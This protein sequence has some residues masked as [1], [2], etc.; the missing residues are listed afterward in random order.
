[1]DA[2]EQY[3]NGEYEKAMKLAA[4][5]KTPISDLPEEMI[6]NLKVIIDN[7]EKNKAV[8]TVVITSAVYKHFHPEQDI[9]NHQSSI[10]CGYSG[11]TFD[12]KYITPFLKEHRFPAMAE[13]GWLTRSLEQ[14]VPYNFNYH[15]AITPQSLKDAFLK[16]INYIEESGLEDSIISFLLQG[17]II[18]RDSNL[19]S[20]ATPQ[21]L[22]IS[23]IIYLLEKHFKH[24]YHS[25]GASRLPVLALYA[26][27]MCISKE[28][29]R[30]E[31]KNLLPIESH[32][33][34]DSRSGR[35]GDIDIVDDKGEAFEAVEVKLGIPISHS[36]V[37]TANEKI[38]TSKM[39]RYY[40]LS[41][42]PPLES[43]KE[44]IAADIKQIKNIHGCQLIIG[45]VLTT[46]QYYLHLITDTKDFIKNYAEL[47]YADK[48]IK[49]EHKDAW[50]KLVST[51]E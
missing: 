36:I 46:L 27:Y 12:T 26:A 9:R 37:E 7:A 30:Y 21:N 8:Y 13:S 3:L 18:F 1:M 44:R 38:Q 14:K 34:A 39:D 33:S 23:N 40:I 24:S 17:L 43:D 6:A 35:K 5:T 4:N 25:A 20:L 42:L 51:M 29:K 41:T 11:R 31:G 50:N 28:M 19:I 22:S 49:F 32:N 47:L 15:G 10:E 45:G 16:S 48:T 2:I